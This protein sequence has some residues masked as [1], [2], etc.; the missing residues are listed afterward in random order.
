MFQFVPILSLAMPPLMALFTGP[1][2][3]LFVARTGKPFTITIM[4]LIVS[5]IIGLLIFGSIYIFLFNFAFFVLAEIVAA[6]GKY[7]SYKVNLT[8]YK[9]DHSFFTGKYQCNFR[10]SIYQCFGVLPYNFV[11]YIIFGHY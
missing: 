6:L 11:R 10:Y 5:L 1:I 3:M 8:S 7:K 2:Y 9:V 4:G